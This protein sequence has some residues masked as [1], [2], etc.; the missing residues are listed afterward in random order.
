MIKNLSQNLFLKPLSVLWD[1]VYQFRRFLF[2]YNIVKKNYFKVPII[3][4][5]NITFGGTGKTPLT[6][7]LIKL[8]EKMDQEVMVLSRGYKGK[9]ENSSGILHGGGRFYSN[10][11]EF[12]DEPLLLS[13]SL[14]KGAV[15]VGKNRSENLKKYFSDVKP[16]IVV[17]DDGFQH[18]RLFRNFNIVLF[19]SLLPLDR[20]KTAPMGYLREGLTSLK[21]ADF[22]VLTRVDQVHEKKINELIDMLYE[23]TSRPLPVAKVKYAPCGIYNCF[24][25][26]VMDLKELNGKKFLLSQVSLLLSIFI[27]FC[28]NMVLRLLIN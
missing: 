19:D 15:V 10:P 22:I 21:D 1:K 11:E 2:E 3:S 5:G 13:R 12:G 26:K 28:H 24:D 23:H 20:Y 6:I 18:L 25:E 16:D 4:V 8:L 9:R 27:I 17:M 14:T 7:W